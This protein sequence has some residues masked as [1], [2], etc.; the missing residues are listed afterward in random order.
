MPNTISDGAGFGIRVLARIIDTFYGMVLGFCGGILGGIALVILDGASLIAPGWQDRLKETSVISYGFGMIASFAYHSLT[1]GMYGASLGK[2]ICQ[3]RVIREDAHSINLWQA[4]KR[5]LAFFWDG[6]FFGLV[7]Y[8]SMKQ[9][10]L[11]QR[12]GDRWAHTVVVKNAEVPSIARKGGE[13]FALALLFGSAC[14]IL[15]MG[16]SVVL[17]GR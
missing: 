7:G 11:N 5:S 1:E 14:S 2:L 8:N 12:Y 10:D 17:H 13:I 6:L 3:L 16:L 15:I 4:A 9:S